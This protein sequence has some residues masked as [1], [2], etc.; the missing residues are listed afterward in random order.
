MAVG[1]QADRL[2]EA[3]LQAGS[4]LNGVSKKNAI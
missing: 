3:I 2:F 4:I 1:I